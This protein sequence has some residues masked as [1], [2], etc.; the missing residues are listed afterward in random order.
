MFRYNYLPY[1][2]PIYASDPKQQIID[3]AETYIQRDCH[4]IKVGPVEI[5]A[6][7]PYN[8]VEEIHIV[9]NNKTVARFLFSDPKA[10][11]K[12]GDLSFSGKDLKITCSDNR[13]FMNCGTPFRTDTIQ[14]EFKFKNKKLYLV[15]YIRYAGHAYGTE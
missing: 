15:D 5:W 9:K 2:K 3:E 1:L 12:F 13:I 8:N 6:V 11:K 14:M 4:L 10:H 7:L